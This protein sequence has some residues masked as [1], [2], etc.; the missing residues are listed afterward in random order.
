MKFEDTKKFITRKLKKIDFVNTNYPQD[1]DAVNTEYRRLRDGLD[2]YSGLI[3][4]LSSYEFGGSVMK[5]VTQLT[6]KISTNPTLGFLKSCDLYTEAAN[7]GEELSNTCHSSSIKSTGTKFSEAFQNIKEAKRKMNESLK[8]VHHSLK[9][10]KGEAKMVDSLRHK[11]ESLRYDLEVIIQENT[12]TKAEIEALTGEFNAKSLEALRGMKTFMGE[13]GLT[14]LL[15]KTAAIHREF[16]D[17]SAKA[18]SVVD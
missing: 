7:V 16:S 6:N 5:N 14:G 18:L 9:T 12:G 8:E 15:K 11:A 17:A 4:K 10:L 2:Y 3:D 1:Y 13:A